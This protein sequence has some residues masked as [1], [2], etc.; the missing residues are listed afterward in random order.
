MKNSLAVPQ[1][2][3]HRIVMA[4]ELSLYLSLPLSLCF[5]PP[6]IWGKY[7]IKQRECHF[8]CYFLKMVISENALLLDK[9]QGDYG[10]CNLRIIRLLRTL[11]HLSTLL[12]NF[13]FVHQRNYVKIF[14]LPRY[15]LWQ[16]VF[17]LKECV[18]HLFCE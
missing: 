13:P 7:S 6:N 2:I 15:I 14:F 10:T 3:K 1:Q 11:G 9:K 8:W 18:L 16:F 4:I 12:K 17:V 5:S